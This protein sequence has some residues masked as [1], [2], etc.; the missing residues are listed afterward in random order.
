LGALDCLLKSVQGILIRI[1]AHKFLESHNLYQKK[2]VVMD[3]KEMEAR[4]KEL[5]NRVRIL[6]HLEA[7]KRLQRAFG[8]YLEHWMYEEI[9]DLFS[10][11]PEVEL[12][13]MVGIYL[14]KEGVRRYVTGE[15]E[16][17]VNP[18]VLH[19]VMQLSGIVDIAPDGKTAEGRWY[20]FG[21]ISLPSDKGIIQNLSGGIYNAKYIKEDGKWKILKFIWNPTYMFDPRVGW[22]KPDRVAPIGDRKIAEPPRPDRPRPLDTRYPSGYIAPFHYKH[23]VTGKET[24]ERKHNASLNLKEMD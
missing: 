17:S 1:Q 14:G 20:G 4:L 22:V 13:I 9:L 3:I 24:S 10:D 8:Y 6:D 5:E 23:P 2:E 7:I 18:E 16:R 11:S 21:A 12:N 15:K 19:Q